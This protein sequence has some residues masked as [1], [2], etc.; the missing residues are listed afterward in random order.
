MHALLGLSSLLLVL[1]ATTLALAALR[2]VAGWT[3]RRE[4]Q[5]LILSSPLI[6]LG[7]SL[8]A[9]HH[10][11]DQV[12]FLEAPFW[13]YLLGLGLPLLLSVVALG[14]LGLGLVRLVMLHWIV[15]RSGL[16]AGSQLQERADRLA[17]R[18]GTPPA[19]ILLRPYNRPLALSLGFFRPRVLL[20]TWMIEHLDGREL[21]AVLAHELG[22]TRRRDYPVIWLATVLRDGFWYLPTSWSAYR[23]LHREKELACDELAVSATGR[24]LALASALT[25]VWQP[26]LAAPGFTLAQPLVESASPIE[27]RIE[28]LLTTPEPA[29]VAPP[30]R[31]GAASV[32]VAALT[33]LVLLEV[34][35]LT[36]L[37]APMGCGPAR[38]LGLTF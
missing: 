24:P 17:K 27:A 23:R 4:L 2:N 5:L 19:Q 13:D 29:M 10:L 34:V 1:L 22:H 31:R 25:K 20:S 35:N 33:G 12:C 14:G 32:A 30:A 38:S 11:S 28:R 26:S 8:A 18:L 21:E 6:G 37:L 36:V 7:A 9:I 3:Q 15:A 16:P